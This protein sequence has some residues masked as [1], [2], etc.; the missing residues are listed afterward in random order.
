VGWIGRDRM[1][2]LHD[3]GA[4]EVAAV[5][6]LDV[7][8]A[9]QAAAAV[10][11]S[12]VCGGLDELLEHELDGVVIA[13]PTALHAEQARQALARGLPVFSQ[14]PLG[15]TA[16]EC[17]ELLALAR[18]GDLTLGVDMSYRHLDAVQAALRALHDGAIGA[19][20]TAELVF[21]NAYGPDKAWVRDVALAGGG[22][23]IDLG[24][25]LLDLALL[26]FGELAV[27]SLHAD[28]FAAGERLEP[29]PGRV[30]DLALAQV[31]LRDGRALRIAC[32]WWLPAGRDAV[33]EASFYGTRRAL[34]VRNVN[35]SFYD[36]EA[37]LVDGRTEQRLAE[38]PDRW[39]G[40]ALVAW[41]RQLSSG[42][43]FDPEVE[44]LLEVAELIDR[45]YGRPV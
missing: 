31:S 26:F 30:E 23:L 11:C 19:P 3:A 7:E 17:G 43:G 13:T 2:A 38:P 34:S 4:G 5:A 18:D 8:L 16:A 32:S 39:G 44:R 6:D 12:E 22:A 1:Q 35:G 41:A 45:I 25:H 40:R 36:F 15:R 10:E 20:H 24:C 37:V 29:D 27:A 14:K 42:G 28:L 21:H 9:R 33:I